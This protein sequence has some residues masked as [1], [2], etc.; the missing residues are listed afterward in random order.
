MTFVRILLGVLLGSLA[1]VVAVPAV[2]LMDLVTGGTGL[3]I[4]ESGLGTCSAGAYVGAE[5]LVIL[6]AAIAL[7]SFAIAVCLRILRQSRRVA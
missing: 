1:L 3:G 4:C 2:V 7:L 6:T 5:L